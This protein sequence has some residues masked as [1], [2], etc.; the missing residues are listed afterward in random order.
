MTLFVVAWPSCARWATQVIFDAMLSMKTIRD[1]LLEAP[2][3][4]F[5]TR[6]SDGRKIVVK[7]P[8]F[9]AAGGTVVLVTDLKDNIQRLDL[10]HIVSLDDV[11]SSKR[12]GKSRK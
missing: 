10:L 3:K 8:E 11:Q 2:I 5:E 4:P 1:R 7:H 6:L 9:I 12:N